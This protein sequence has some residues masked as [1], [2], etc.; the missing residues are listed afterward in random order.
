MPRLDRKSTIEE[1]QDKLQ[2]ATGQIYGCAAINRSLLSDFEALT[3]LD[4]TKGVWAETKRCPLLLVASLLL[5]VRPGAPSSFFLLLS[6]TLAFLLFC[7]RHIGHAR[8]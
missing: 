4:E 6:I 8:F 5:V 7:R 3:E 1:L 2:F